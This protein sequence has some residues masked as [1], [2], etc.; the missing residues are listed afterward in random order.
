MIPSETDREFLPVDIECSF[1]ELRGTLDVRAIFRCPVPRCAR[2]LTQN[3]RMEKG[4]LIPV[5]QIFN[6]AGHNL[7]GE[8]R[9][10]AEKPR[11]AFELLAVRKR[12]GHKRNP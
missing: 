1:E 3:R 12:S 8:A 4:F 9:L 7:H 10:D 2:L 5:H 6:L 11:T